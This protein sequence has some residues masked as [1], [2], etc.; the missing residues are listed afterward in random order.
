[1]EPLAMAGLALIAGVTVFAA[2]CGAVGG[3]ILWRVNS[4]FILGALSVTVM[5]FLL[6]AILDYG[7]LKA[8]AYF[9]ILPL[10]LTFLFANVSARALAR[11]KKNRPTW[12]ALVALGI[13]LI[14]GFLYLQLLRFSLGI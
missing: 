12:A 1:M 4:G 3:A 14:V 9:G 8:A 5:Y 7:A 10:L 11:H 13:A 2:L 6:V